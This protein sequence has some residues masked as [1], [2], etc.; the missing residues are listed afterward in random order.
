MA[1]LREETVYEGIAIL[2]AQNAR[3]L[4]GSALPSVMPWPSLPGDWDTIRASPLHARRMEDVSA[5]CAKARAVLQSQLLRPEV[6][7]LVTHFQLESKYMTCAWTI[8]RCSVPLSMATVDSAAHMREGIILSTVN[9]I[10][11]A[12]LSFYSAIAP[13]LEAYQ[14]GL[15]EGPTLAGWGGVVKSC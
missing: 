5:Q 6:V 10:P 13:Q 11:A 7:A 4:Q 14:A 2:K 1:T 15:G 9:S 3:F 12:F 8:L